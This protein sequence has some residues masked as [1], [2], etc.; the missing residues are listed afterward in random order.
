MRSS[1]CSTDKVEDVVAVAIFK[2]SL[3]AQ[4]GYSAHPRSCDDCSPGPPDR[5]QCRSGASGP[6]LST[7]YLG[8]RGFSAPFVARDCLTYHATHAHCPSTA[9]LTA[10]TTWR[11]EGDLG[12][13]SRTREEPA[14]HFRE[15]VSA[16]LMVIAFRAGNT[17]VGDCVVHSRE[18]RPRVLLPPGADRVSNLGNQ[19]VQA[20]KTSGL[21]GAIGLQGPRVSI[22]SAFHQV[23]IAC[24]RPSHLLHPAL[25]TRGL[26]F[27]FC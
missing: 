26:A 1:C 20:R 7:I 18:Y 12:C 11:R 25:R 6:L 2:L 15:F 3:A 10:E 21:S 9:N 24:Q 22:T 16:G 8:K 14:R 4:P 5:G 17:G 13:P 23:R 27:V 19:T